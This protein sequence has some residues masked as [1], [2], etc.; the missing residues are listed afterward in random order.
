MSDPDVLLVLGLSWSERQAALRVS[1][2]PTGAVHRLPLLGCRLG[3][4][5]VAP[6][7]YCTGWH[8][9]DPVHGGWR[10]CRAQRLATTSGQ[11]A[12]CALLDQFRFV[13]QGH[14][15]GYVPAALEHVL[16]A[17]H[18]LY[19]AT[20]A[21]GFTK[22]GTSVEHRRTAR[23]DEQGAVIADYVAAA[24]DGRLVREA[25]DLVT[26]ELDVPQHRRRAAKVAALA[27]PAPRARVVERH[28]E[29]V[30]QVAALLDRAGF[31]PGLVPLQERW[32]PPAAMGALAA[33]PPSG[34][35]LDYPHD[36]RVG[37]HGLDVEACAG[38]A[39]LARTGPDVGAGTLRYL[40]D[41]GRLTGARI[42]LGDVTSP[43]AEVQETLF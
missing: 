7:P 23:I 33:E 14:L 26:A 25:E 40:V 11:C 19:L 16:T 43:E 13:H 36:L 9:L 24:V 5:T 38:P 6:G 37:A 39:V 32:A 29:T 42:V 1:A 20:F 12:D 27:H 10:P 35:W 22:V 15:G 18:R 2:P 4:T 21:D 28:A 3:F 34:S 30:A 8:D 41:L 17:P 31:G